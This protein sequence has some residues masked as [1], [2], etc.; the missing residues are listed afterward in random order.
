MRRKG[1]LLLCLALTSSIAFAQTVHSTYQ[2]GKIWFKLK[3]KH[4]VIALPNENPYDISIYALPFVSKVVGDF[5]VTSLA[6]PFFAAKNDGKLQRT[7]ELT[8]SDI[9]N[10]DRII[11]ALN[12]L[13]QIEYAERVPYDQ[14]CLT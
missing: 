7:Y 8:F 12:A 10:V 13:P 2:D 6:K 3:D 5:D 11:A 4:P 1:L 9:H 14:L